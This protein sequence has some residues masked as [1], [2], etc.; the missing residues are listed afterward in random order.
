V[1]Q[2]MQAEI[3]PAIGR[4]MAS[5]AIAAHCQK[6]GIVGER[7]TPAELDALLARLALGLVV[8]VGDHQAR[9]IGGRIRA[10]L[11]PLAVGR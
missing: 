5:A 11:A 9:E 6:L 2:V 7:L 10:Q 1:L 3:A 4:S 8:F